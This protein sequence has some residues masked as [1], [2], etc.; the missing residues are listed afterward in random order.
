M[1]TLGGYPWNEND[2]MPQIDIFDQ[3]GDMV[4]PFHICH[5]LFPF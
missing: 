3:D 4:D 1:R 5:Q 2:C